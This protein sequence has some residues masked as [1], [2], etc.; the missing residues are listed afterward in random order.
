MSKKTNW[1]EIDKR[2]RGRRAVWSHSDRGDLEDS[3]KKLPDVASQADTVDMAQ[4]ALGGAKAGDR[5]N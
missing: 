1:A 2:I 5:S 4:P 3:L